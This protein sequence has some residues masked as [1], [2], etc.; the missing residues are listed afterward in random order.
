MD[1]SETGIKKEENMDSEMLTGLI[2]E[3][4]DLEDEE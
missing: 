1:S 2:E 4:E 3:R